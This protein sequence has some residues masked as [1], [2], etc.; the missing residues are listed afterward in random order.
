MWF[1]SAT[2]GD[3]SLVH[4]QGRYSFVAADP[5]AWMSPQESEQ[6]PWQTLTSWCDRLPPAN[7]PELPPFQGGIAG[8][9]S[10]EAGS[11]LEPTGVSLHDDLPTPPM[12]LG[13]YDVVFAFDHEQKDVFLISQGFDAEGHRCPERARRRADFFLAHLDAAPNRMPTQA[14][15]YPAQSADVES[16]FTAD[17]F[18][19]AIAEIVTR[20]CGG[21]C[22]QVNIAQRLTT[23]ATCDSAGLY[24]TL[25]KHNPAP[26]AGFLDAGNHHVLSSSPEGFLKVRARSVETRPIKGTVPRTGDPV[27]DSQ[28][29]ATLLASEKDLAE[30]V[31]IVDL[32]RNDLSR[33][34]R[35]DSVIADRLCQLEAYQH[36]QH[37]VSVVSGELRTDKT[38]VDLLMNSFPGGSVT[39]APKIEAMRII[40]ELE[41]HRRGPYCGSMGYI[42]SQS[43]AEFN[44]LIRTITA[45]HG[46]WQFHVGGG[47][48]ARSQP[49][50]ELAETWTKAKGILAAIQA[51]TN[52]DFQLPPTTTSGK[53]DA[54]ASP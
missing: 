48:T 20:I 45:A 42:S 53:K 32:M 50:D 17:D 24:Q 51:T 23:P 28:H 44:I 40:A 11:R 35:D 54:S 21:D 9:I 36:V 38:I 4:P 33:V 19:G 39:G 41:P 1:D 6:A 29:A 3:S 14:T 22:F 47:I 30:N 43:D 16:N 5:V 18:V 34:C 15:P 27:R 8:V 7:V 26:F 49:D 52:G 46:T 25:R 31:M 37:L 13:L 2:S 10:Y 12:S